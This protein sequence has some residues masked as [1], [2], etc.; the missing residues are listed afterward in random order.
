VSTRS[1]LRLVVLRVLVITVL[2]TLLGRL[3]YLQVIAGE[4]Y[5]K[6]AQDNRIR[7]VVEPAPRGMIYDSSGRPLVENR[8][9]MVVS[10][11]RSLLRR[12]HD[13]GKDVLARL[14][15]VVG[16]RAVDIARMITPCGERYADGRPA[17]AP[18]CW[19]GSPYQP[20]PIRTYPTDNPTSTKP[21]LRI[22][23]QREEFPGVTAELQPVR[24]YPDGP[25]AAHLLGYLGPIRDDERTDPKFAGL[26]TAKVGRSGVEQVYDDALRGQAGVQELVV[27]KDGNVTGVQKSTPAQTGDA[28]VLSLD[29]NVQKLAEDAL[30]HGMA[31][32]RTIT[33][34]TR[35]I[36]Y[37][38]PTGAVVVLEARTGRVVA[39]ASNPSY[40]PS[41]F[42]RAKL[43]VSTYKALT[44]P[45]KGAPLYSNAT[46]GTF[47]PGS[48][49]KISSTSAAVAAGNSLHGYYACP[50]QLKVGSQV[51]HNYEGETFGTI[52]FR[53]ALIKSCDTVYYQLAYDQW[54]RDGKTKNTG[55]ARE[56]FVKMARAFGFGSRTGVDLPSE[57]S[58]LI[59]DRAEKVALWKQRK[60]DYCAGAKRRPKGTYLQ[61][62]DEENC[63]DGHVYKAGDAVNFSIGQGDVLATPLQLACAYAALANGGTLYEP[64]V[65]KAL[66][67]AD[68]TRVTP[69]PLKVKGK[70][71]VSQE[72]L[73]Y[74][75]SALTGVT[76]PGGTAQGAY[77]GFPAGIVAGKT[78]TAEVQDKQPTAWFASFAPAA[79]PKYVVVAMVTEGGTGGTTAAPIT[80]EIWDGLLGLEGHKA[81]LPGG[82]LPSALP[83]VRADGTVA[84]PGTKTGRPAPAV[85]PPSPSPSA[86][87]AKALVSDRPRSTARRSPS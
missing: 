50:P 59:I 5:A 16:I 60:D 30:A 64:R 52:D 35:G 41:I 61:Q 45:A 3:W 40:D 42:T 65:A 9:V 1:R 29:R 83:V 24:V 44:D 67:S 8:T 55:K 57:S 72:T 2:A 74:I 14:A 62:I 78:G 13:G 43:P 27:D 86:S 68:G 33:D 20:V 51:F 66:L 21:A 71:P 58:G 87:Q 63:V 75:R 47:A 25:L 38:A 82:A 39:M 48:T 84:P 81:L 53:T 26:T 12:E 18:D 15:G 10:V 19:N 56:V 37:K 77:A 6:A 49:F 17:K 79:A 85:V 22:L 76:Q 73:S 4:R 69:I 54:L 46:Q 80:R 32:A 11:N 36:K 7:E 31:R 70:L 23:E 28:L 34:R